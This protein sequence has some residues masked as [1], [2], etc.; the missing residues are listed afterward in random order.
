[1]RYG[2]RTFGRNPSFTAV[3]VITLALG[4]GLNT[5]IFTVVNAMLFRGLSA[6]DAHELV[7]I[8]QSVQGVVE[9]AGQRTF[10]TSDYFAYRDRAQTLSGL[11]AFANARGEATLG[12]DTPRKV[13][14]LL[15]SCNYFAVLQQPPALGRPLAAHDCAPGAD[16]VVVLNYDLWRTAFASDP[17]IVGRTVQLNRQRVTVVGVAAE[18]AGDGSPVRGGYLAPL[19]AGRLLSS[20][21]TRYDDP[22]SLWLNLL[23]RRKQDVGL[24]QVRAEL[25]VIAAQIDRQQPGRTTALTIERATDAIASWLPADR[26][27]PATAAGA[28]LMAAFGFI[29]VIAC[30]NVANLLLA[31]GTS[32][33][34]EIGI[35]V[36]LGASRARV[37]RQLVT[38]SLL[39]SLA[40][41]LLGSVVAVWSFQMLA[42]LAVPALLPPWFPLALTVDVSPDL[43]VLSFALVVTVATGILFGLVPALRI[44]K[45]D[46]HA[47]MKNRT[48]R[49]PAPAGGAGGSWRRS[50]AWRSHC[51][52]C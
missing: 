33:G 41:G 7:A 51:A 28:V 18:G 1:M 21:D 12:A 46:L 10:S 44:S 13:L 32:R 23:G 52:W 35:R 19:S 5:G 31:R 38:E 49:A 36:S 27:G 43:R 40:G 29:L 17:G 24:N 15:V 30:A 3:A 8:S 37:V 2:S 26:R 47:V 16:P 6:P 34:Q 45:P 9:F 22:R 14:G 42:E 4:I 39:I 48:P 25:D 50:S 20:G 11:A